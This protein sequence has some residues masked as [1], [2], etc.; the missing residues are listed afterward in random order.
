MCGQKGPSHVPRTEG[1]PATQDVRCWNQEDW[2]TCLEASRSPPPVRRVQSTSCFLPPPFCRSV[3]RGCADAVWRGLPQT[4]ACSGLDL[5][6]QCVLNT[7]PSNLGNVG[8]KELSPYSCHPKTVT[9]GI[10]VYFLCYFSLCIFQKIYLQLEC[11]LYPAK[12]S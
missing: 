8:E 9:I 7:E 10:L 11:M 3:C 4:V 5:V 2:V 6:H 12:L 1:F